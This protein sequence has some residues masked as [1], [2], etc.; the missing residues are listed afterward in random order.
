[1]PGARAVPVDGGACPLVNF[2]SR[3]RAKRSNTWQRMAT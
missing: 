1:M 3:V 2:H